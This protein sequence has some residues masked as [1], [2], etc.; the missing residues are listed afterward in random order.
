[1]PTIGAERIGHHTALD[2]MVALRAQAKELHARIDSTNKKIS[3]HENRKKTYAAF[4]LEREKELDDEKRVEL[5]KALT[6]IDED[7]DAFKKERLGHSNALAKCA[8]DAA[9]AR[10]ILMEATEKA[11]GFVVD[12]AEDKENDENEEP[13]E[14]S[15]ETKESLE[16]RGL[17]NTLKSLRVKDW[18]DD[19]VDKFNALLLGVTRHVRGSV[20]KAWGG[21][22]YPNTAYHYAYRDGIDEFRVIVKIAPHVADLTVVPLSDNVSAAPA[23]L[24]MWDEDNLES[25]V[26]TWSEN[27]MECVKSMIMENDK[28]REAAMLGLLLIINDTKVELFNT[29]QTK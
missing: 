27:P 21:M 3:E 29:R 11:A 24:D 22:G 26:D 2:K 25:L 28:S 20:V 8:S 16:V 5:M 13:A 18:E 9:E 7:L 6:S 17:V 14:E 1:V 4:L 19:V 12:D 15:V 10:E 23:S